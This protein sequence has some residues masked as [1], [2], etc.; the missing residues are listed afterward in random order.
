MH[1][2]VISIVP[3]KLLFTV[4]TM[5]RQVNDRRIATM[6]NEA[7]SCGISVDEMG[8]LIKDYFAS[9]IDNSDHSADGKFET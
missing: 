2:L 3:L 4:Q 8:D 1:A 5:A 7:K 9:N 6:L